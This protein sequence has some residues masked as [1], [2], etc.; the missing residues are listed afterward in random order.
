MSKD[1]V[2]SKGF[3]DFLEE[4]IKLEPI[5]FI[6]LAKVLCAPVMDNNKE[7]REFE[8]ILSDM[9]DNFISTGR[10]QRRD[11]LKMIKEANKIKV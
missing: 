2:S 5:E 1:K 4:V 7:P 10:R 3:T 6:G 11:I 9:M 8:D